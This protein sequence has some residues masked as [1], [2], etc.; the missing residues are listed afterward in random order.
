MAAVEWPRRQCAELRPGPEGEATSWRNAKGGGHWRDRRRE[1]RG[2]EGW[3]NKMSSD[4]DAGVET[5]WG[6]S[7]RNQE[8]TKNRERAP[9]QD[10]DSGTPKTTPLAISEVS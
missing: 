8:R 2:L 7:W 1:R 3:E 4:Q 6:R 5:N 9:G 10:G